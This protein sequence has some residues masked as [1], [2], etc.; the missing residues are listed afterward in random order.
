MRHVPTTAIAPGPEGHRFLGNLPDVRQD[1]IGMFLNGANTYGD[2]VRFRFA[3]R[4]GHLLRHP[5]HVKHV[6]VDNFRNYGK[7]TRGFA[8]LRELLGQGLLTSEGDFWLRQRRIAQPAFHHQQIA[9]FAETMTRTTTDLLDAWDA[10]TDLTAPID[11][12]DSMMALTLRIVGLTLLS[13]D[14]AGSAKDVGQALNTIL[15]LAM[16]RITRMFDLPQWLPTKGNRDF[17]AAKGVLDRL[18]YEIIAERRAGG[19]GPQDLLSMLIAARDPDTGEG[20]SDEQLRDEVMT[21]FLAGHETTANALTWTW[22]LLSKNPAVNSQLEAELDR[23][24]GGRA[25]TLADLPRLTYSRQVLEESMRLYPPAWMIARSVKE[26]DEIGG[27]S[28]P[29]GSIV[30]TSP[31]VSH[32]HPAFWPNPEGFDPDRFAPTQVAERPKFAYFPFGGGPRL[33]IGREFALMEAHL[34]IVTMAQRYQLHLKAGHPV[35]MEPV[36]TLRPKHGMQ[37]TRQRR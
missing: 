29:A 18:I 19:D 37:M 6:L 10:E 35:I 20:M 14:V 21:I 4:V 2:V 23:E 34:I 16:G 36:I 3:N 11:I 33:C 27:Y 5:D 30:F 22:Y 12:A 25:P 31:L 28:I 24:L 32:R 15:H 13:R 26:A 7:Q 9:R 8:A 17:D 1:A